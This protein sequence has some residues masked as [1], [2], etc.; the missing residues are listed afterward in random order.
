MAAANPNVP[1]ALASGII[2]LVLGAGLGFLG[3]D[4]YRNRKPADGSTTER[5]PML[6]ADAGMRPP[7]AAGMGGP[8][9]GGP[10]GGGGRP[11]AG[12]GGPGGMMMGMGG[13]GAGRGM[14]GPPVRAQLANLVS[15]LDVLTNK[16]KPLLIELTVE[17]KQKVKEQL[18]GLADMEEVKD[19]EAKKRLDALLE[20]LKDKKDTLEAVGYR[21]PAGQGGGQGGGP[22]GFGG[23]PGGGRPGGNP[24]TNPFKDD[25]NV[26]NALKSLES[27]LGKGG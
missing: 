24:S 17:Q 6:G 16:D 23:G 8:P 22:G 26:A 4:I 5:Q 7:D 10:G 19:E 25:P 20:I 27:T 12:P 2:C 3:N 18:Q 13:M 15:K 1:A 21:W 9:M 11:G 14:Q